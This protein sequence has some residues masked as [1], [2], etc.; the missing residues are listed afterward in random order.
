[1]LQNPSVLINLYLLIFLYR[2]QQKCWVD[3]IPLYKV[4]CFSEWRESEESFDFIL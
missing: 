3:I 4:D 2:Q 1:M